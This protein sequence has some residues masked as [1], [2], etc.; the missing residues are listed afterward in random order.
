MAPEQ[1]SGRG[2]DVRTDIYA[3]GLVLFEV[4]TGR[5]PF[6]AASWNEWTQAHLH[7]P[8]PPPSSSTRIDAA[9][10]RTIMRCLEKDPAQRPHSALALSGMLPGGDALAMAMVGF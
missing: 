8:P 6:A 3:H 4:F 10:E 1:I 7:E 2:Y 5:R 9:I